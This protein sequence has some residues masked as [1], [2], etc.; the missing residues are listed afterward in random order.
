LKGDRVR[1]GSKNIL[2]DRSFDVVG[3]L[4]CDRLSGKSV[5]ILGDRFVIEIGFDRNFDVV[6]L[7]NAIAF[8]LRLGAIAVLMLLGAIAF[9][10]RFGAI[11][12]WWKCGYFRRSLFG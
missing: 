5:D 12:C 8:W 9:W 7:L 6:D 11:A 3:L 2:G 10:L 4:K 1:G